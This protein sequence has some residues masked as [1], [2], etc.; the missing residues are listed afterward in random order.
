MDGGCEKEG[1]AFFD[2]AGREEDGACDKQNEK[3]SVASIRDTSN[4]SPGQDDK[5]ATTSWGRGNDLQF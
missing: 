2:D 5:D 4:D 1:H 3:F